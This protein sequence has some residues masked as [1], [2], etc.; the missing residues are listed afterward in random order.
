MKAY[1]TDILA[2]D[3][4]KRTRRLKTLAELEQLCLNEYSELTAL[5]AGDARVTYAQLWRDAARVRASLYERGLEKGQAVGISLLNGVDCITAFLAVGTAGGVAV[6]LPAINSAPA[7]NRLLGIIKPALVIAD[8]AAA[9]APTLLASEMRAPEPAPFCEIAEADPAAAFFTGGT[10][11]IMKCALLSHK[12]LMTGVYNGIFAPNGAYFQRYLA[13][14][15]LSHVFGAIRNTLTCLQTGSCLR[16]LGDM[17]S[18]MAEL[19]TYKPTLLVLVPALTELLL[20]VAKAY[21]IGA[22]GGCLKTIIAGGAPV[23]FSVAVDFADLGVQICPGYGLTETANLVS[24]KADPRTRGAS[25][26]KPY[27]N[28]ELRFVDGEIQIRGDNIFSYYINDPVQTEEA[29]DDGW[30]KTGDLGHMDDE[31]FLYI[32][33]RI[34]SMIVLPSGEKISPEEIE[35][36]VDELPGVKCS[37]VKMVKNQVGV[38]VLSCEVLPEPGANQQNIREAIDGVNETLPIH[39]QIRQVIMREQDFKRSPAMKILRDQ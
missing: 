23:K 10:S 30:F 12:A 20:S 37:L 36:L 32:T 13:V 28:Q 15:P 26:G 16:L 19:R 24:G 14:L 29:F 33:G 8:E 5:S 17:S 6:I 27:D 7:L 38:D 34:K 11:G 4:L 35:M 31:G 1:F 9:A 3:E 2:A 18:L 21:G 22:L 39:S 25:V